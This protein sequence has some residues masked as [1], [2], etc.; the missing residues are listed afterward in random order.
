[1]EVRKD[2]LMLEES[3]YYRSILEDVMRALRGSPFYS[4]FYDENAELVEEA[5][6]ALAR[7]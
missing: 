1:M 4:E 5:E 2:E 7:E 6:D 3:R